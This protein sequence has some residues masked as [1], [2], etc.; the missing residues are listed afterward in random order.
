MI[1][2]EFKQWYLQFYEIMIVSLFS[3]KGNI[4]FEVKEMEVNDIVKLNLL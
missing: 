1:R 3:D 4:Y 2:K